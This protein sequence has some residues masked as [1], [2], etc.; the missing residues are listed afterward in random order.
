[1][2][3]ET[4]EKDGAATATRLRGGTLVGGGLLLAATAVWALDGG[5]WAALAFASTVAL[6]LPVARAALRAVRLRVLDMN[7]L[8][9]IAAFGAIAIDEYFD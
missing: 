3:A 9:T 6:G 7:A 4:G 5:W 8:M 2:A 1:M